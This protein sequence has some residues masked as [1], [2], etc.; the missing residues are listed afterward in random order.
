MTTT[1]TPGPWAAFTDGNHTNIVAVVP[2]T[3]CV[4]SLQGH[5]KNEPNVCLIVAAPNLLKELEALY[6]W[7]G[8][9]TSEWAGRNTPE[10]QARLIGMRDAIALATGR[11]DQD[12]Q[13]DYG[14]RAVRAKATGYA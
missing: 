4:F 8:D 10:G 3:D 9:Y 2:K 12:V 1:H 5:D 13:D 6:T 11:T 14:T 7:L